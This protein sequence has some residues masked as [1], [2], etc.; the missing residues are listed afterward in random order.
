MREVLETNV[1]ETEI[2]P[3]EMP[4][5]PAE[6]RKRIPLTHR[7]SV[8]VIAFIMLIFSAITATA[9][10]A[11]ALVMMDEGIYITAE[12]TYR[13]N[14]FQNLTTEDMRQDWYWIAS[15]CI[16]LAYLLRYWIY[17]IIA[18]AVLLAVLCFVFLMCASGR[19][20][21]CDTPQPGWGTWVPVDVLVL[22]VMTV[23][24]MLAYWCEE[25]LFFHS[26]WKQMVTYGISC[27]LLGIV[28]VGFCMSMALRFKL[29]QWWK[30]SV[31]WYC[32][33]IC[34]RI[35][36]KVWRVTKK[37]ASGCAALLQGIPLVWRT[38]V[39]F[40]LICVAELMVLL[41][42]Y[43]VRS[44]LSLWLLTRPLAFAVIVI[45][46]LMLRRLQKGG[47]A[48]AAGELEH[49]VDTK[50]LLG[51]FRKHGEDLNRIGEGM[52]VAVEQRIRSER[53]KTE[54]ITNVSHDIKT[55]LTSIINYADLIA[56]E[57]CE[58]EKIHDYAAVLHRQSERLKRL[59]ED[60]V[61][62]SKLSA[63][64]LEVQL[65]PC[66]AGVLLTQAAG[67][68]ARRLTEQQLT[69]VTSQPEQ[70][71]QIM[72]D[73]RRL[74]RVFD[75]LMSN[76]CKYGQSGTRVYLTLEEKNGQA[77][78]TFRNTSREPLN[79]SA[80]ELMERFV[81]G[82]AARSAGGSGLGL[83]IARSLTELQRGTM[84]LT[85]DGDLFK[86]VLRFPLI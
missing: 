77:V 79:L 16:T 9:G 59:L 22:A 13:E 8:K 33:H 39:V 53:M 54:L 47:E 23:V 43:H 26:D 46:A 45:V 56:Q 1:E 37:T 84:E 38:A 75:N 42:S 60:L 2:E 10:V 24:L 74:W 12:K 14:I 67:E 20:A 40:A 36:E 69:L 49:Q 63:G 18:G 35:L 30:N 27:L 78:I 25:A 57:P 4:E 81:R 82:D 21:G 73:G 34:R 44:V 31:V 28:T 48:L 76:I 19:R 85:V 61:E 17:A 72:A 58:N 11:A 70:P 5:K 62:A 51:D 3:R 86:V 15:R 66:E 52:S 32:L 80:D 7:I 50:W 65:A 29:G 83:S 68:Y 55:P 6:K 41:S 71:V 64:N